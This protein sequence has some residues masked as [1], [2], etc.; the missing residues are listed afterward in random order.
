MDREDLNRQR[1]HENNV[2]IAEPDELSLDND[3]NPEQLSSL[4]MRDESRAWRGFCALKDWQLREDVATAC[5]ESS[6]LWDIY[7]RCYRRHMEDFIREDFYTAL[8]EKVNLYARQYE[9][10]GSINV[11]LLKDGCL[12]TITQWAESIEER[13]NHRYGIPRSVYPPGE[14]LTF[15]ADDGRKNLYMDVNMTALASRHMAADDA[16]QWIYH[17]PHLKLFVQGVMRFSQL[18][19]YLSDLG[20]AVNIMR[21]EGPNTVLPVAAF[22]E[23]MRLGGKRTALSFHFDTI[24]SSVVNSRACGNMNARGATG[25]IGIQDC[26]E[27]GERVTFPTVHRENVSTVSAIVDLYDPHNPCKEIAGHKP[28]VITEPTAGVLSLFNG[29]DVLHGVSAVTKG[30]RA[31]AVFLYCEQKPVGSKSN[32]DSINTFYG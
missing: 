31:A 9:E 19:P 10:T 20:V 22:S 12:K 14:V 5:G 30:L 32:T 18:H 1:E 8:E 27:G 21:P 15:T 24:D 6:V 17:L 11:P 25:V 4:F 23:G 3:L 16:V 2:I 29:G 13:G 26:E 7:L 28:D